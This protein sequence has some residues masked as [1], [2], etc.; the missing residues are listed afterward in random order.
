MTTLAGWPGAPYVDQTSGGNCR[1]A[2]VLGLVSS[3]LRGPNHP[4]VRT[5][6]F[7]R[8]VVS[9]RGGEVCASSDVIDSS[10]PPRESYAP[11]AD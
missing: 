11:F 1:L 8:K 2:Y 3:A 7:T 4:F 9:S 6:K 5:L 10:A